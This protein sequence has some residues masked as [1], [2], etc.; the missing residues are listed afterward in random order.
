MGNGE[1]SGRL[2]RLLAAVFPPF[3]VHH[4]PPPFRW[5][6]E[7]RF[8]LR[9]ELDAA[10]FHLYLPSAANGEWGI[11]NGEVDAAGKPLAIRQSLLAAFPTPRAAVAYILDTFPIVKRKDEAKFNGDYRTKRVILE[12]YDALADA[13]QAGKVYET[14]LAP[15]PASFRSVHIPRLPKD[16]RIALDLAEK[17]LLSFVYGFLHQTHAEATF[18]LLDSVFHLLR[19]RDRHTD[20]FAAAIGDSAKTWLSSCNYSGGLTANER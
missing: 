9:C 14:R 7:R 19:Q 13:I 15:I 4:S 3:A 20:E 18:D 16:K 8:L 11:A 6:E 12:I 2:R 1:W 5:D 17:F 10:F